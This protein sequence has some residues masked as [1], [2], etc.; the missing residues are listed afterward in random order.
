MKKLRNFV[1]KHN[2]RIFAVEIVL[3]GIVILQLVKTGDP[4]EV[5]ALSVV[6]CTYSSVELQW[7]EADN[8][9]AYR[10][11]R[12]ANGREYKY[13][14]FTSKN[15]YTDKRIRTGVTY[16][17]Y[18]TSRNGFKT[19]L[20]KTNI[21]AEAT[22]Q[23]EAPRLAVDTANGKINLNYTMVDGAAYYEIFRDGESLGK[24]GKLSFTDGDASGDMV[25]TYEVKAGRYVWKPV[26]SV[27][28]NSVDA[29]LYRLTNFTV[30]AIDTDLVVKW[31]PSN[32]YNTYK[33]YNGDELLSEGEETIFRVSD[34][35][36]SQVYDIKV[37]G[38]GDNRSQSPEVS[39]RFMVVE[40]KMTNEDARLAACEWAR[41]IAAD[42]SFTYGVGGRAHRYGCYFCG[43]NT[44]PNMNIKGTSLVNGHSYEK[45]YCCNPFVHAAYAHGAGDPNMLAACQ[46]GKGVAM[47]VKSYTR[48]GNWKSVGKPAKSALQA[49]DVLVR[50]GHVM[51]YVGGGKIA[52]AG[53]EGWGPETIRV[54][55]LADKSYGRVEFVMRYTGNG[56]GVK[57]VIKDVD[58]N[59]KVIDDT[60]A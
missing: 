38:Y 50:S 12:S 6:D 35:V 7:E 24:T 14:D 54:N 27:A 5:K 37:V 42:N 34:F 59:G 47:S 48:Y 16:S 60:S 28:S 4:E 8:A 11:Y 49:G 41:E 58:Q 9:N 55:N 52:H 19:S 23:L 33:V 57:Y 17:Y 10:I 30:E 40:E 26:Y 1:K 36:V 31:D 21:T 29:V 22:P 43:T 25:H 44:G 2:L 15:S 13:I 46:K 53:G 32:H 3:I 45:T 18:V 20:K 39:R 56:R 51:L